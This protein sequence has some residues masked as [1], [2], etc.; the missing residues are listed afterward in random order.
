M[1]EVGARSVWVHTPSGQRIKLPSDA[2]TR[3]ELADTSHSLAF[4]AAEL[5]RGVA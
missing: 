1:L 3:E 2:L 5:A 4:K